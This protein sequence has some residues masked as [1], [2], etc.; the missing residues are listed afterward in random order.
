MI[1]IIYAWFY[2]FIY[3]TNREYS[4][5]CTIYA[6]LQCCGYRYIKCGSGSDY[7]EK[8]LFGSGIKIIDNDLSLQNVGSQKF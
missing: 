1:F 4:P 7:L 5:N 8:Y 2:L 3:Y 6:T